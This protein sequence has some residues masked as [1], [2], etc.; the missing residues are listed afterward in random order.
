MLA[1]DKN[2]FELTHGS[3]PPGIVEHDV[4]AQREWVLASGPGFYTYGHVDGSG[5][6]TFTFLTTGTK[7]W[8]Y[9]TMK[10]PPDLQDSD[11]ARPVFSHYTKVI[12]SASTYLRAPDVLPELTTCHNVV[13]RPGS[14]L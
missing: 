8:S 6:C 1:A 13:L 11:E 10:P 9:V 5:L 4:I 14:L 7:L 3:N 2:A 12:N